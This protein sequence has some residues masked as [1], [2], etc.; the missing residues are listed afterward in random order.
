M[1]KKPL[2]AL[3]AAALL[4]LLV[5]T[6]WYL[7]R[8]NQPVCQ[9][10][11]FAMDTVMTFTAYGP[12]GETA[13]AAAMAEVQ[14]LDALWSTGNP[15]SEVSR[16]NAAGYGAVS[17]DTERLLREAMAV[18]E[19]T[20]GLFDYTIYPLMEL[21]GFSSGEPHVPAQADVE[22]TLALVDGSRLCLEDGQV[23]LGEGQ[24]IDLGGIGK[25][26][27]S[28]RIME[29]FRENGVE[30]GMVSLG[31]NV[32]TLGEKPDGEPWR[33]GIRDPAG[34]QNAYLG[35]LSTTDRAVVTSGGYERYFE[36]NGQRYIHILD[37]RTGEPANSGL[38]SATVVSA[39]GSLADGLSTA[40][41]IMGRENATA[42]WEDHR[43][44]F[45][46]ILIGEDR[47]VYI[48]EGI[49]DSFRTEEKLEVLR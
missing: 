47:S 3:A 13:V 23:V 5:V 18:Y 15:S 46:M 34:A 26:F 21:W 31:G 1:R 37:P 30:A 10:Q 16:L 39:D 19:K 6:V 7:R 24:R 28:A 14:R 20:G 25:G 38:L 44:E 35:V 27:A 45:D 12:N 8:Q 22:K 41:F 36:E 43:E 49:Y 9:R 17:A 40:L 32:Q 29:V 33:I 2:A 11:L 4:C 48:T 42:F